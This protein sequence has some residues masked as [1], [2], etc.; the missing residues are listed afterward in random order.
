MSDEL[1]KSCSIATLSQQDRGQRFPFPIFITVI[2]CGR[3]KVVWAE[4]EENE[5][6][7]RQVPWRSSKEVWKVQPPTAPILL[8]F[9]YVR[10]CTHIQKHA[11]SHIKGSQ[12]PRK[13][14][15][16]ERPWIGTFMVKI[17]LIWKRASTD[18]FILLLFM[19]LDMSKKSGGERKRGI[20]KSWR[21]DVLM[22]RLQN[23]AQ[24]TT[25]SRTISRQKIRWTR[26]KKA[27]P[28]TQTKRQQIE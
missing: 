12:N 28:L 17:M 2:A 11:R 23:I 5:H 16:C 14:V 21:R 3:T 10:I 20:P 8:H 24:A 7:K 26:R 4:Q 9:V 22:Q 6:F 18:L 27:V 1:V 13:K 15:F 19:G 25:S